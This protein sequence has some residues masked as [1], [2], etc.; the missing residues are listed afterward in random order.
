MCDARM[1]R[2]GGCALTPTSEV[3]P[4]RRPCE[5][6]CLLHA[7]CP[8]FR[9]LHGRWRGCA[10]S[11]FSPPKRNARKQRASG[12]KPTPLPPQAPSPH[13]PFWHE[14]AQTASPTPIGHAKQMRVPR[15]DAGWR[16]REV[17]HE[18]RRPR[19]QEPHPDRCRH[20]CDDPTLCKQSGRA[21]TM[22]D[23]GR[24][25]ASGDNKRASRVS[26][27]SGQCRGALRISRSAASKSTEQRR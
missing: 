9:R 14:R 26:A 10:Y 21:S 19:H 8:T 27:F 11:V 25:C 5:P 20:R 13:R 3:E 12:C 4:K 7:F 15:Q 18:A 22:T 23:A 24:V 1:A 2:A 17:A 16:T 6:V